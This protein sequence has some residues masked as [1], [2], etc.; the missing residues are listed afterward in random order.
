M[1]FCTINTTTIGNKPM[2]T[3]DTIQEIQNMLAK[4]PDMPLITMTREEVEELL[5]YAWRYIEDHN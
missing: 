3:F 5:G 2:T 4:N 1:T